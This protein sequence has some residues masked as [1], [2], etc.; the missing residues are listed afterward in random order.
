M[1]QKMSPIKYKDH[2]VSNTSAKKTVIGSWKKKVYLRIKKKKICICVLGLNNPFLIKFPCKWLKTSK[3][4]I[5][6]DSRN[7]HCYL[8]KNQNQSHCHRYQIPVVFEFVVLESMFTS[9]L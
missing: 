5:E 8:I 2:N 9:Y 1:G 3:Q 4:A 6:N 7:A